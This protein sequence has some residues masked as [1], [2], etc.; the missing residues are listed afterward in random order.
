MTDLWVPHPR[1]VLVFVARVGYLEAKPVLVIL[2][3]AK[4]LR[5]SNA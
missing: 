3:A 1:D 5:F 4:D 2:S